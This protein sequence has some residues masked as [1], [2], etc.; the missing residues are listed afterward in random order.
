VTY[1]RRGSLG[2]EPEDDGSPPGNESKS[3]FNSGFATIALFLVVAV[4]LLAIA[5]L[6]TITGR[7]GL[8]T[9]WQALGTRF[10][11]ALVIAVPA[12]LLGALVVLVGL[13]MALVEWR[14]R[15]QATTMAGNREE[16]NVPAIVDAVGKLRGAAL[17]MVVGALLI[18]GSAWIAQSAVAPS[19]PAVV[20]APATP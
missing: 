13:W 16:L 10:K 3:G 20:A 14:S 12:L 4:G 1:V 7:L 5:G 18:L 11:F 17:V 8:A 2:D 19:P 6:A 9:D 15:F